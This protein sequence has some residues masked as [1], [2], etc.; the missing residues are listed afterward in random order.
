MLKNNSVRLVAALIFAS[1]LA[2]TVLTGTASAITPQ[3]TANWFWANDTNAASV[4][5]GDVDGDGFTEIVTVGYYNDGTRW[6]AQ[7]QVWNGATLAVENV[8]PWLWGSNTQAIAV[9]IGDVDADGQIEIVTGGSY[10]DGT[11]WIAQLHV[12]NGATLAVEGVQVWYW[13]GDTYI[14][15]IAIGNADTDAA[16]EII[17][18]G[19]YNDG[20]RWI[21]QLMVWNGATLALEN[22]MPWFWTGDTYINSVAIGNVDADP[23]DEIVT[24][25]SYFDGTRWIAQ[26]M[27][28]NGATLALEN[29]MPWFWTSDT[30]VASVAIGDVDG[31]GAVEIV[32]GGQYNNNVL[33]D[34]SV[35]PFGMVLR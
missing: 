26:L 4:A 23:A 5:A 3:N 21:A 28:W 31:D 20:T 22:V 27:V 19:A 25:G 14:S 1:L 35:N 30:D 15:S 17:T 24:G 34:C 10:F 16:V 7:L 6:I 18:G 9:S 33:S 12:W 29:V 13:T 2:A 32:T 8:V 11:R